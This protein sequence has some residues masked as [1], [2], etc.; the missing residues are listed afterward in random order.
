MEDGSATVSARCNAGNAR[1]YIACGKAG[2]TQA[3][4]ARTAPPWQ[5]PLG[6]AS[7]AAVSPSGRCVQDERTGGHL[8]GENRLLRNG[9]PGP[10]PTARFG[11]GSSLRI[12]RKTSLSSQGK[13]FQFRLNAYIIG[14]DF[15]TGV[16]SQL[17][18]SHVL[19]GGHRNEGRIRL[20]SR[21][22]RHFRTTARRGVD[23]C[24]SEAN[25]A[26]RLEQG[27]CLKTI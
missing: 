25:K 12:G 27:G 20:T 7:T 9:S 15:Q 17:R 8:A 16:Q 2:S 3:G 21:F 19:C 22:A 4:S 11:G 5:R 6:P 13:C 26:P 18:T 10:S 24:T 1:D 23:R 14:P